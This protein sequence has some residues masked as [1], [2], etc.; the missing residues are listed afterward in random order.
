MKTRYRATDL[1]GLLQNTRIYAGKRV[2]HI[3]RRECKAELASLSQSRLATN[4][5]SRK[6]LQNLCE[7]EDVRV[8]EV[9]NAS[10]FVI[11]DRFC[12]VFTTS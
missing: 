1:A 5:E 2:F 11:L 12:S 3:F 9:A 6:S 4:P 8:S 10:K 7:I